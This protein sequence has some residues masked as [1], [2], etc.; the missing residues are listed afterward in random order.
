MTLAWTVGN[1][2]C[3]QVLDLA[4]VQKHVWSKTVSFDVPR[5]EVVRGM[6]VRYVAY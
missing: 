3:T 1:S 5:G 6:Q 2:N 4:W